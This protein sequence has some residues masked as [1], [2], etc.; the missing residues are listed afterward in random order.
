MNY[1]SLYKIWIFLS[2]SF[3]GIV[4]VLCFFALYDDMTIITKP[5]PTLVALS[6]VIPYAFLLFVGKV[7]LD[8]RRKIE[9]ESG[10]TKRE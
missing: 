10:Y 9:L 3:V 6:F 5:L 8:K 2:I 1:K 4:M 7:L